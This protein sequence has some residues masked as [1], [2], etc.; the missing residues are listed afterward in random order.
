MVDDQP[1]ETI[2]AEDTTTDVPAL[3]K[4]Y[5]ETVSDLSDYA[6]V[7]K[8]NY[9][10]RHCVWPGQA[11]DNRKHGRNKEAPFP[12]DG[13][14]DLKVPLCDELINMSV[15]Q[16]CLSLAK[17]NLRAVPVE[18]NDMAR[19]SVVSQFLKWLVLSQ[20]KELPREA[21]LLANYVEERG[22]GVMGV[23]WDEG[24]IRTQE[25]MT[26]EQIAQAMPDIAE[27]VKAGTADDELV[28]LLKQQGIG[29]GKARRMLRE[30]RENGETFIPQVENIRS[31]PALKAYA[32]GDDIFFPR[33]IANLQD[34][35]VVFRR[36]RLTAT[37]LREKIHT[38]KW[39]KKVVDA[40]ISAGPTDNASEILSSADA[41][42]RY[43]RGGT[44]LQD[45]K[46]QLYTVVHGYRRMS[47]EDGVPGIYCTIFSPN[48]TKAEFKHYLLDYRHGMYPFVEFK[49]EELSPLLLDSRG[50]PEVAR[51]W[52]DAIKV[53]MD[54]RIDHA[55][56]S[57]CPPL[58]HP[59]GRE[60]TRWGAGARVAERRPG[61]FHYADVPHAPQ[62]SMEIQ[63]RIE[64]MARQ[65]FG[66]FNGEEYMVEGQMKQ[67]ANINR[68]LR[69]WVR[70]YEHVYALYKQ[71]GPDEEFFR[72][73]GSMSP[74]AQRFSKG[75]RG[76]KYDIYLNFDVL[77][78][79]PEILMAKYKQIGDIAA[80][81]DRYGQ[82]DSGQY[83]QVMIEAIDPIIAERILLPKE[84]ASQKEVNEEQNDLTK[85]WSGIDTDVPTNAAHE[86]RLQVAQN[87]LQ[88]SQEIPAL[89]V[90]Q[91]LQ[92]DEA[93]RARMEKH[94]KQLQF[95]IT[96]KQNAQIG[97]L[98]TA[99]A[100]PA[101]PPQQY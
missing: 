26:L 28:T 81:W 5:D 75:D 49:R 11:A 93:F 6:E 85:I 96:Q 83:L 34:S 58:M 95:A 4:L 29:A 51:V 7:Q 1:P 61:E 66:R 45:G 36:C 101:T 54:A 47:D 62:N 24:I 43:V 27:A 50:I 44:D 80:Q 2:D 69:S 37:Q 74:Q 41:G 82:V 16:L 88:G 23:F 79:D 90:Q 77:N 64:A 57:T 53:E 91:R 25:R 89:D 98:G 70:V 72:V 12:W 84:Q 97:R 8:R 65:Y 40:V 32:V 20:I 3:S 68:W 14:S 52:Q 30:L 15:S 39:S 46:E 73:I 100:T 99:P 48:Y 35:S 78:Q 94:I 22:I 60:P 67:Q 31:R 42:I 55:S 21:E 38:E 63:G 76:E 18:G 13:A 33:N 87:Y 19:A 17:A 9:E 86:I 56:L 59:V 92:S 71:Y 10:G